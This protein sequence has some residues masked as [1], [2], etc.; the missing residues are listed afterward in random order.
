MAIAQV[1]DPSRA[2]SE[3]FTVTGL[4]IAIQDLADALGYRSDK[5]TGHTARS[6]Y[7]N[8]CETN[9][10]EVRRRLAALRATVA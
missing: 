6:S 4:A 8:D 1:R 10:D 5:V 2:V 7:D 9:P 3:D